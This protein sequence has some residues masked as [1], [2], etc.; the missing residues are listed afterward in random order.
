MIEDIRAEYRLGTAQIDDVEYYIQLY[1]NRTTP[2]VLQFST[3]FY[4]LL[5]KPNID[6]P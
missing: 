5:L 2:T 4:I 6:F 1:S 3:L